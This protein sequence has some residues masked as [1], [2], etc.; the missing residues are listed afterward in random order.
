MILKLTYF[1]SFLICSPQSLHLPAISETVLMENL[2]I[3]RKN[4]FD[5]LIDEDGELST[6]VVFQNSTIQYGTLSPRLTWD[7]VGFF[8]SGY[9]EG[10]AGVVT[11]KQELDLWPKWHW[12]TYLHA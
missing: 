12:R 10:K 3:F 6:I 1:L 2:E 8:S 7:G 11:Y 9:A 5:F 4:G